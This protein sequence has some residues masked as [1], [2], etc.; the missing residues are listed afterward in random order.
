M[1]NKKFLTTGKLIVIVILL[2][3]LGYFIYRYICSYIYIKNMEGQKSYS[4]AVE[5]V[6]KCYSSVQTDKMWHRKTTTCPKCHK[7]LLREITFIG[8]YSLHSLI[9]NSDE[10]S[11]SVNTI[12]QVCKNQDCKFFAL[13]KELFFEED[14]FYETIYSGKY[15]N[16]EDVLMESSVEEQSDTPEENDVI[17]IKSIPAGEPPSWINK[18]EFVENSILNFVTSTSFFNDI[19]KVEENTKKQFFEQGKY[20]I[21]KHLKNQIFMNFAEAALEIGVYKDS[22]GEK[23]RE[24]FLSNV[25]KTKVPDLNIKDT[26][27]Q[28]IKEGTRQYYR[29]Y[30]LFSLTVEKYRE[31]SKQIFADT[32]KQ[33]EQ[34]NHATDLLKKIET[35]FYG[36]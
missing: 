30:V 10:G 26:Y 34:N 22:T 18:Y 28:Q 2:V 8:D 7:N 12:T 29:I 31:L 9:G 6:K 3:F 19:E 16:L 15:I 24:L 23:L 5:I 35:K 1:G 25:E 4:E 36:K 20:D 13:H 27:I 14:N 11:L 32:Y 33:I 17:I 21:I